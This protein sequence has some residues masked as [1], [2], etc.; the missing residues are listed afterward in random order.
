MTA[1][2]DMGNTTI[3]Y[4]VFDGRTLL[5]KDRMPTYGEW[6]FSLEGVDL[7]VVSSVVPDL[8]DK[9]LSAL[10]GHFPVLLTRELLSGLDIGVYDVSNLGMDRLVDLIAAKSL[11]K[12]PLAVFDAGTCLTV[13]VL[14]RDGRFL[15]GMIAPGPQTSLK[16]LNKWTNTLPLIEAEECGKLIGESTRECLL[17]G[18]IAGTAA[19]LDGFALRIREELGEETAFILTGGMAPL[20]LPWCKETFRHEPMLLLQGLLEISFTLS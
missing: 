16:A 1:V 8:N 3:A 17:S 18:V 14:G 13:S 20:V 5:R 6:R 9:L 10:E 15:G 19:M 11:S 12:A 2:V 4:A 7:A